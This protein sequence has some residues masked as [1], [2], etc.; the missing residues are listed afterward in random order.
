MAEELIQDMTRKEALEADTELRELEG[1]K[2]IR[3]YVFKI[4]NGHKVAF[5]L[6]FDE[7]CEKRIDTPR[8]TAYDWINQVQVTRDAL[9]LSLSDLSTLSTNEKGMLL[10]VASTRELR[11]I[12]TA[13]ERRELWQTYLTLSDVNGTASHA[14]PIDLA[15]TLKNLIAARLRLTAAPVVS[16]G[17]PEPPSM[18]APSAPT[19]EP[20]ANAPQ[21]AP[22]KPKPTVTTYSPPKETFPDTGD[23]ADVVMD[24]DEQP[25]PELVKANARTCQRDDGLRCLFVEA[26]LPGG[27]ELMLRIPY[28]LLPGDMQP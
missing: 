9:G 2:R 26:C 19:Q 12:E 3:L 24:Y 4:R 23:A 16:P 20:A 14:F 13:A 1:K 25:E 6:D 22:T 5:G 15:R 11:K 21:E 8:S 10:P 7:Y 17:L 18:P 28:A 27:S